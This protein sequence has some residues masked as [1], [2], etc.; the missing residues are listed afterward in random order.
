MWPVLLDM[1]R[2]DCKRQLRRL[3]LDAYATVMT[4]FRAQG[5]LDAVRR[6]ILTDLQTVLR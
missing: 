1:P 2:D 3:E 5:N 6:Q 4:A